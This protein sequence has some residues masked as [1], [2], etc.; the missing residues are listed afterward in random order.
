MVV[1]GDSEER[2]TRALRRWTDFVLGFDVL[3]TWLVGFWSEMLWKY[4]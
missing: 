4:G 2:F 3:F 1:T